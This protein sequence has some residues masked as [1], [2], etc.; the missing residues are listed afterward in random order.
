[1]KTLSIGDIHGRSIWKDILFG[2]ARE[3]EIWRTA[4]ESGADPLD[5]ELWKDCPFMSADKI[6]FIGDYVDS[7]TVDNVT[8]LHNLNEIVH[9]RKT[10]GDRVIL[11]LGNHDVQYILNNLGCSGYRPEM[12]PDLYKL[13]ADNESLFSM[14]YQVE[15]SNG[16]SYLWTHA[17]VTSGWLSQ[18]K[19]EM[20]N[21]HFRFFEIVEDR[22]PQTIADMLNLAW[23]LNMQVL[24]SVDGDSGGWSKWAG[25][26]WVRPRKLNSKYLDKISQIV[27][28]TPVDDIH[29]THIKWT[30]DSKTIHYYIDCLEYGSRKALELEII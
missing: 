16:D 5:T 4:T 26:L 19:D 1:M 23:E 18:L 10:V 3:Y 25:P 17:G 28:H 8:M 11:L 6:I 13:F 14:A 7:F 2:D 9:F 20:F 30:D 27:G 24:H 22:K 15:A 12:R 29:K 21:E